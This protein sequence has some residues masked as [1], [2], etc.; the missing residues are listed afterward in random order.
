MKNTNQCSNIPKN[1][2][3]RDLVDLNVRV[4]NANA[5]HWDTVTNPYQNPQIKMDFS[6][7]SMRVTDD[8]GEQT[9]LKVTLDKQTPDKA[10]RGMLSKALFTSIRSRRSAIGSVDPGSDINPDVVNVIDD[11]LT[12]AV[13]VIN[14]GA[15]VGSLGSGNSN[16]PSPDDITM[17]GDSDKIGSQTDVEIHMIPVLRTSEKPMALGSDSSESSF[18]HIAPWRFYAEV[19]YDEI[20]Q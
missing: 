19:T 18:G 11:T 15:D 20:H 9:S 5:D 6:D 8:S 4:T 16:W 17:Q 2:N 1:Q 10:K 7:D 12:K 13:T 14:T 3:D